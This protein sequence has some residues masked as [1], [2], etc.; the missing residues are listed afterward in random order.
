M[1]NW[2]F[3]SKENSKRKCQTL[4][5]LWWQVFLSKSKTDHLH[6]L[7][8]R[9]HLIVFIVSEIRSKRTKKERW[10]KVS[11][12]CR[13]HW[14]SIKYRMILFWDWINIDSPLNMILSELPQR[15]LIVPKTLKHI[16][17][18]V[19]HHNGWK[20]S[21][22]WKHKAK[23]KIKEYLFWQTKSFL[24]KTKSFASVVSFYNC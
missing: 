8:H 22:N 16:R 17:G 24:W 20:N 2:C 21:H 5:N 23:K 1:K 19:Y 18:L 9:E 7:R 13:V 6:S 3:F 11:I 14:K 12:V 10:E 4:I 15:A